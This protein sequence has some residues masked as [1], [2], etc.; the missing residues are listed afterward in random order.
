[1]TEKDKKSFT[2]DLVRKSNFEI[3]LKRYCKIVQYRKN[4]VPVTKSIELV[5]DQILKFEPITEE[6]IIKKRYKKES[7]I[8]MIFFGQLFYTKAPKYI[9]ISKMD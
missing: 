6:E 7:G 2:Y 8:I 1:M 5:E 9:K 4:A 3:E